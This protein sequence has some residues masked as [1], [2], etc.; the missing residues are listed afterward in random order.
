MSRESRRT[1]TGTGESKRIWLLLGLVLLLGGLLRLAYLGDLKQAPDYTYPLLDAEYHDY[2]ARGMVFGDWST[3]EDKVDPQVR[4]TPYFRPPAYPYFLAGIYRIF[5]DGY[6]APRVIQ[7]LLGLVN[8]LLVFFIARRWLNQTIAVIAAALMSGYWAFI[9][10][11]GEFHAPVLAIFF[12]LLMTWLLCRWAETPGWKWALAVGLALGLTILARSNALLLL[13][14]IAVWVAT[15]PGGRPAWPRLRRDA[16]ALL[17]GLAVTILPVTVRNVAKGGELVLITTALGPNLLMGNNPG[18]NGLCD[19]DLPGYGSFG[20]CY[21][22]PG[23]V[24]AAR[25][26]T[27]EELS[28]QEVSRLLTRDAL[29]YITANPGEFLGLMG[30]R[31]LLYWGPWEATHN[32]V[33]EL[34]RQ[35]STALRWNPLRY[36]VAVALGLL[37]VFVFWRTRRPGVAGS[38]DAAEQTAGARRLLSLSLWIILFWFLSILPFFVAARYRVP[39]IPFLLLLGAYGLF[40][41]GGALQRRDWSVAGLG[42]AVLVGGVILASINFIGYQPSL[43]RW[44]YDRA[45]CLRAT[46]HTGEAVAELRSTLEV[47]RRHW[48]ALL[49]LGSLLAMQG[50]LERGIVFLKEAA[51]IRPDDPRV[52]FNLATGLELSGDVAG[53]RRAYEAVL[54][55]RPD[56]RGARAGLARLR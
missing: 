44:H 14:A 22:W 43:A 33:I 30:K 7:M 1:R 40:R 20:T 19:G 54:R 6:T 47:D 27:G 34:E 11:E 55:L 42:L 49:D 37:G 15:L 23:I 9:Y 38:A 36:P 46:G 48:R 12:L 41:V 21:D 18:A 26:R 16:L 17:V 51:A 13:G 29:E 10:F 53:A 24:A 35:S 56:D 3:P 45:I 28:H 25:A 39:M 50:Q 4:T 8:A 32:K 52:Q 5:G 31:I 2:W